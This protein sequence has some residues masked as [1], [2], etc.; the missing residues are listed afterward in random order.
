[1]REYIVTLWDITA[2]AFWSLLAGATITASFIFWAEGIRPWA[3]LLLGLFVV[4]IIATAYYVTT[5]TYV[6]GGG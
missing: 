2:I 3:V 6:A 5:L 4:T 1:M